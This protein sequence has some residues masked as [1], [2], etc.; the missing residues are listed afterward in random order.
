MLVLAS[1]LFASLACV[2]LDSD[3]DDDPGSNLEG[4]TA[5]TDSGDTDSGDTDSGDTDSGDTDSGDTDPP[6]DP[7]RMIAT[8][9]DFGARTGSWSLYGWPSATPLATGMDLGGPDNRIDCDAG[10]AVMLQRRTGVDDRAT[11]VDLDSGAALASV[12]FGPDAEPWDVAL[13]DEEWWFALRATS[14]IEITDAVGNL[15]D[16]IDLA[17]WADDD[18]TAQPASIRQDGDTTYVLLAGVDDTDADDPYGTP[19]LLAFDAPSRTVEWALDLSG[20]VAP[21]L[22]VA[23]GTTMYQH[24]SGLLVRGDVGMERVL[25]GGIEVVDLSARTASGLLLTEA[26]LNATIDAFGVRGGTG[27]AWLVLTDA[28]TGVQTVN[29]LDLDTWTHTEVWRPTGFVVRVFTEAVDGTFWNL[30]VVRGETETQAYVHR[31]ASFTELE[32]FDFGPNLSGLT[33]CA[34][35]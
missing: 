2:A 1:S 32:R 16:T 26:A 24:H 14:T 12:G 20:R 21:V 4:D 10:A 19:R 6:D 18:G 8:Y 23:E 3:K 25:A 15:L 9:A 34:A 7:Q 13:V 5:D 33:V 30:E 28:T 11:V 31:D 22:G 35:P 17:P 29:L 27:T